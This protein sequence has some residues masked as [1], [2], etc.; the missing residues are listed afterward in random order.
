MAFV[1][2]IAVSIFTVPVSDVLNFL[3]CQCFLEHHRFNGPIFSM[4]PPPST[5]WVPEMRVLDG[6]DATLLFATRLS[7]HVAGGHLL[8]EVDLQLMNLW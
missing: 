1:G 3:R 8:L 2:M 4:P 7:T 6:C 5:N